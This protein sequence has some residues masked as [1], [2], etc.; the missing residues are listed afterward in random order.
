MRESRQDYWAKQ[1]AEQEGSGQTAQ[2]FCRERG[3]CA[4]TFYH[5]RKRLR[6]IRRAPQFALVKTI[7]TQPPIASPASAALELIFVTGERLRIS[8]GADAA[9][10]QLA[11]A[12]IRA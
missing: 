11:L 12:A 9:T 10:L 1:I 7:E 3:L 4:H 5:W 8:R 6:K 2:A